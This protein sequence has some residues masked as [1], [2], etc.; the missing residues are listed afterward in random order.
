MRHTMRSAVG[1]SHEA[2]RHILP[3]RR[4]ALAAPQRGPLLNRLQC[5]RRQCSKGRAGWAPAAGDS[6]SKGGS[7]QYHHHG[8]QPSRR[9]PATEIR[10]RHPWVSRA[11]LPCRARDVIRRAVVA[12]GASTA[13]TATCY[14]GRA[15][16]VAAAALGATYYSLHQLQ[17]L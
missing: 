14:V 2:C 11:G 13:A 3:L 7:Q 10:T 8:S 15:W 16:L 4:G 12:N 6:K 5:S 9:A 17:V 1:M